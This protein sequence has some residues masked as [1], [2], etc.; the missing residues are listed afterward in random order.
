MK[1]N[2]LDGLYLNVTCQFTSCWVFGDI[3]SLWL[4]VLRHYNI[5]TYGITINRLRRHRKVLK[6]G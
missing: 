1:V 5:I 6:Q 2:E 4:V 3:L